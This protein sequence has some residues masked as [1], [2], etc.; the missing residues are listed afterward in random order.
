MAGEVGSLD[1]TLSE[2]INS[3]KLM[4]PQT[5]SP[6]LKTPIKIELD[7][8]FPDIELN[9]D[10]FQVK[11]VNQ[12][13]QD[14]PQYGATNEA[15]ISIHNIIDTDDEKSLEMMFPGAWQGT[16][17]VSVS[18]TILGEIDVSAITD[19]IVE[20]RVTGISPNSGSILGGTLITITGTNFGEEK[21][22]NPVNINLGEYSTAVDCHVLTTSKEEITCRVDEDETSTERIRTRLDAGA[23]PSV[24]VFL[25]AS[26]EAICDGSTCDYSFI[27]TNSL[28]EV[29]SIVNV[30][31]SGSQEHQ[32]KVRGSGFTGNSDSTQLY[33][34]GIL[35][36]TVSKSS[37]EAVFKI[38]DL[39]YASDI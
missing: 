5:A 17:T 39:E 25:K 26:E 16:Y 31:D 11:I 20:S 30:F 23:S 2:T 38:I 34:G 15:L 18:H 1:L 10:D 24:I 29:T 9:K 36:E 27:E 4:D 12:N 13:P 28:P 22:D 6:V 7:D 33:V 21:T 14:D 8:A 37:S 32:V 35:Q 19:F 3:V